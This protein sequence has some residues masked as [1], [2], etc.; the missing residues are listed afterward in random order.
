MDLIADNSS[1]N[2]YTSNLVCEMLQAQK[3]C[4]SQVRDLI[5]E[6]TFWREESHKQMS[7]I[8]SSHSNSIDK[9]FN[10]LSEEVSDLQAQV[11]ILKKEKHVLIETVD[12]LN[13]EIR[14]MGAKLHLMEPEMK[15]MES[16]Q[17]DDIYVKE[18]CFEPVQIHT[19]TGHEEE[20]IDYGDISDQSVE[21]QNKRY[22]WD[23]QNDLRDSTANKIDVNSVH[24]G[25][26][27]EAAHVTLNLT[28]HNVKSEDFCCK[29]CNFAFSTRDN[30]SIHMNNVHTMLEQGKL[31]HK[32]DEESLEHRNL[33]LKMDAN[34]S[35][36]PKLQNNTRNILSGNRRHMNEVH[37]NKRRHACDDCGYATPR[38]G[39][40]KQHQD[41]VHN[42]GGKRFKCEKCPYSSAEKR[43]LKYHMVS[44]HNIGEKL[45]C[46]E[47]EFVSSTISS[48]KRHWDALHNEGEKKYKCEKCPYSSARKD[49]LKN[50]IDAVHEKIKR[51]QLAKNI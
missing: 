46:S 11:T 31:S 23:G 8:I 39:V 50:H 26:A 20:C 19:E 49:Q 45:K 14:Q 12:N 35:M 40:L 33:S 34:M 30:L 1:T 42:K 3:G 44:V 37:D 28:K 24:K 17:T 6:L 25:A 4:Q 48:L 43:G 29:V 18:E 21:Q 38:K 51:S 2:S 32:D 47:C 10:D 15:E 36:H 13:N 22:S 5:K 16:F 7:N 9:G 41:A 27:K